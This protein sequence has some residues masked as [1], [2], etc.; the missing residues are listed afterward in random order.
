MDHALKAE[1]RKK[2]A[3]TALACLNEKQLGVGSCMI[4]GGVPWH[5]AEWHAATVTVHSPSHQCHVITPA[6]NG[7]DHTQTKPL[8]YYHITVQ[9]I[10]TRDPAM[11]RTLQE[12]DTCTS[13]GKDNR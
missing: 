6:S 5:T 8:R 12:C 7:N 4:Q 9:A 2:G 11:L 13:H 10:R 3:Q 1:T